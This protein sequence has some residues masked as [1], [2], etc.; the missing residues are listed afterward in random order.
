MKIKPTPQTIWQRPAF[1]P[2]VHPPLTDEVILLAERQLG[3]TLPTEFL[4]VLRVQNGGSI[5]FRIPESMGDMIAGIG[6]SFPS[7][8]DF[9]LMESQDYVDFPLEG[10]VPFDGDGHW[11][12][13][14]DFR[15]NG[16]TPSVAYVDVE[17]NFE[18]LTA[19]TFSSFL[20]QMELDIEN[21]LVLKNVENVD[22][23]IA[24][25][26]KLFNS[27]FK[28]SISNIGVKQ[29][30]LQTGKE[31]HACF[32]ITSNK[33]AHGYADSGESSEKFR[34]EGQALLFPE[35][36]PE[37]VIFEAPEG[38]IEFYRAALGDAGLELVG[39]EEAISN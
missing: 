13:C 26:E 10:L 23:A 9:D 12:R 38:Y 18:Y 20:D 24:R 25:L 6:P 17:C 4:D 37:T 11:Y 31:R 5:R 29:L 3:C 33:V 21:E 30:T 2:Y 32:W 27:H 35:L 16:T 19:D 7:I 22:D 1:L 34:F 36:R 8:T 15:E 28:V 39:I 14:L